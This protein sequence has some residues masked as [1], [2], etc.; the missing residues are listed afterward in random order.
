MAFFSRAGKTSGVCRDCSGL[1]DTEGG[2]DCTW[3]HDEEHAPVVAGKCRD[4][5]ENKDKKEDLCG[6]SADPAKNFKCPG[7]NYRYQNNEM[8]R[9]SEGHGTGFCDICADAFSD[10]DDDDYGDDLF[11]EDS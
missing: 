8:N 3:T 4:C 5:G 6:C 9:D 11:R 10:D 7:C 1:K 2:C